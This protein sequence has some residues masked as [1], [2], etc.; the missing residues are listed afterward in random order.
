MPEERESPEASPV[1]MKQQPSPT[2]ALRDRRI[3]PE[4]VVPKQA[5]G[6]V[7]AGLAVL[8][9]LAVMFSKQH[10]RTTPGALQNSLPFSNDA[11]AR[12]I[13]ELEQTL[14]E[15]QRQSQQQL[16]KQKMVDATNGTQAGAA[17]NPVG[18]LAAAPPRDPIEDAERTL[19]F[20]SR[21]A[22]NLVP[23]DGGVTRSLETFSE[24]ADPSFRSQNTGVAS[25][26]PPPSST[27]QIADAAGEQKRAPE[28]NVNAAHG[29][30]YV[31]FEGTTFD[32][33]LTNRLNGDF[34]GPVKVMLT[35]PVY[36]H[37]DQHLLIP[38]GT[39]LLGDAQNRPH[40]HRHPT[41]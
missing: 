16:Q 26:L 37:D 15:E 21:F 38:E 29:Q 5:Q 9:L 33:V 32:T 20:R 7:V 28:V 2:P 6:Y 13:A 40:R 41:R 31:L 24:E 19:A 39:F 27:S 10:A 1:T 4:G 35:N 30:P 8:I 25:A 11:N 3:L 18:Q 12:K 36:S 23:A 34:A 17:S 14:S 22:S